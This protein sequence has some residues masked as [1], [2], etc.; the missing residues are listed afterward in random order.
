MIGFKIPSNEK[1]NEA[2][3]W[4]HCVFVLTA[5]IDEVVPQMTFWFQRI[6]IPQ[7]FNFLAKRCVFYACSTR[8]YNFSQSFRDHRATFSQKQYQSKT[9]FMIVRIDQQMTIRNH[10]FIFGF[11]ETFDGFLHVQKPIS[12]AWFSGRKEIKS[13]E[14]QLHRIQEYTTIK[15]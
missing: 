8:L 12:E 4:N 11:I 7:K 9:G 6:A 5:K 15:N 14:Y 2:W 10:I 13:Y 1:F 3:G